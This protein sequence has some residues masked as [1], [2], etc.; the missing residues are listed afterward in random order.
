MLQLIHVIHQLP[1]TTIKIACN[2]L[3]ALINSFNEQVLDP[4]Q[5]Q[6]D[7]LT[8]ICRQLQHYQI[9][10]ILWHVKGHMKDK[11]GHTLDWWEERNNKMDLAAKEH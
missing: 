1:P 10:W 3:Q 4:Y 2:G 7:L 5:S 8:C 9:T 6:Y 11:H